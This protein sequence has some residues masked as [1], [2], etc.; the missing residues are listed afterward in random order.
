MGVDSQR[1]APAALPLGKNRYPLLRRVG[2]LQRR[3]GR[4]SKYSPPLA[5]DPRTVQP[6]ATRY[7][8]YASHGHNFVLLYSLR[9]TGQVLLQPYT[10]H[11]IVAMR[12]RYC[13]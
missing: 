1:R 5:F 11:N 10:T 3:Y 4:V 9:E 7:T 8:D 13:I 2:G 6:V 12:F